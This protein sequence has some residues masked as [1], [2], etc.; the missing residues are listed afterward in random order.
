MLTKKPRPDVWT[1]DNTKEPNVCFK[2]EDNATYNSRK[3]ITLGDV[4]EFCPDKHKTKMDPP[5]D[6]YYIGIDEVQ[7]K[8]IVHIRVKR[9]AHT[10]NITWR[11]KRSW[12]TL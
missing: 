1:D 6:I 8:A 2:I 12:E 5:D 11:S 7:D 3:R 10:V 4:L 9:K